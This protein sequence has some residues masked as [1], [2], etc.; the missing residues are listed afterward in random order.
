MARTTDEFRTAL[1]SLLDH[2]EKMGFS[3]VGITAG[4]L[5]RCVGGYPGA[6]HRMPAC[7][8]AM[9]GVMEP[10]D[11]IVE[12]PPSGKGASLLIH[13]ALPRRPLR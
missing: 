9:R 2:A 3:Y 12:Q 10:S 13:F 6:A 11:R 7:C 1:Q 5:H 4:S 8:A